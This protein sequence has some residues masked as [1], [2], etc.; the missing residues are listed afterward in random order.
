MKIF[1]AG[2]RGLVGS[3]I[4]KYIKL[5]Y[6]D[7][8]VVTRSSD[9]LDLRDEVAVEKFMQEVL[10]DIVILAA[11]KVGGILSN[12]MFPVDFL[13]DNIKIQLNVM[14][15]FR[16]IGGCRLIFLGSNCIYPMDCKNPIKESDFM[17]GRLEPN[18]SPYA[19]SKISGVEACRSFNMQYNTEYFALMPINMY[20]PGDHYDLQTCHVLPALIRKIHEASIN[21]EKKYVVW[22]DGTPR[23]EFMYSYDL[24]EFCVKIAL[25]DI[26]CI[27]KVLPN[28]SDYPII[29]VG[30]GADITIKDLAVLISDIVGYDGEIVFDMSKPNGTM[31]KL[32]DN[33]IIKNLGW[34]PSTLLRDGLLKTY[35]DFKKRY[36]NGEI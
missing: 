4:Y 17:S 1:V 16:K 7:I 5:N 8:S 35:E 14:H 10:P 6:P 27:K 23:R 19:V 12:K 9:Q 26:G 29:N 2:H 21:N 18:N 22:G 13:T 15:S 28:K 36:N 32:L 20:G 24:A 31:R 33:S 25:E 11:A 3:A 34:Q 30:S